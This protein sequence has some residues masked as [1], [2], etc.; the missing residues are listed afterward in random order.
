MG[1]VLSFD[2]IRSDSE[3]TIVDI[4]LLCFFP[5]ESLVLV[6]EV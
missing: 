3:T 1:S 4:D 6:I 5:L 2:A